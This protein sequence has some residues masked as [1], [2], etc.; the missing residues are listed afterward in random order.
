[1]KLCMHTFRSLIEIAHALLKVS[2][3][4]DFCNFPF[5][6]NFRSFNALWNY[7]HH[8][9][10]TVKNHLNYRN[11]LKIL[12]SQWS[13][14]ITWKR[15]V[16]DQ[17]FLDILQRLHNIFTRLSID[18]TRLSKWPSGNEFHILNSISNS[19]SILQGRTGRFCR[20]VFIKTPT[21][22]FTF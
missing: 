14:Q 11:Y 2:P 12:K 10:R 7:P 15:N 8:A 20:R 5:T 19:C 4:I 6:F 18:A 9:R 13:D 22:S 21:F 16:E 1:M 3:L 17:H